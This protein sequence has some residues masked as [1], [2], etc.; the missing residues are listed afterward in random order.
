MVATANLS[1]RGDVIDDTGGP[2]V[3]GS[4]PG[5]PPG[6]ADGSGWL[7]LTER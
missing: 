6:I 7:S 5:I 3:A 1:A 4:F 2:L